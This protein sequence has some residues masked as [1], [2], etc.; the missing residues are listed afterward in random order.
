MLIVDLVERGI[1]FQEASQRVFDADIGA[2]NES[3]ITLIIL[4]GRTVDEGASVELGYA[5]SK[6]KRC[7]GYS[8]DPRCILPFG[9]NPMITCCLEATFHN[10]ENFLDYLFPDRVI[11]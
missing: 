7:F 6:K 3:D 11:E 2:I 5:F 1:S 8:T 9:Q 4:D 10:I